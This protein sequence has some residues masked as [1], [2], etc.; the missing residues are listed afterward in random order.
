MTLEEAIVQFTR[1]N[2]YLLSPK[3]AF[4]QCDRVSYEFL[5]FVHK[6]VPDHGCKT[7]CFE[8]ECPEFNFLNPDPELYTLGTHD[9]ENWPK[10]N[11]HMIVET[12]TSFIDWTSRQYSSKAAYPHVVIKKSMA[13]GGN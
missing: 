4:L 13:A 12:P 9:T 1:D 10:A 11:W 5:N 8:I 6:W 2:S 7:Y 3:E